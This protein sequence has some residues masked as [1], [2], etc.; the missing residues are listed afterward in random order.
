MTE[1]RKHK[2]RIGLLGNPAHLNINPQQPAWAETWSN[3]KELY[4]VNVCVYVK[5]SERQR[6]LLYFMNPDVALKDG[7]WF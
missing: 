4:V 7:V 5:E 3:R 2:Q 6:H 1:Q